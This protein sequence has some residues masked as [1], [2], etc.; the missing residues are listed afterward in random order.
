MIN[1]VADA[2]PTARARITA[3]LFLATIILGIVAQ[4]FISDRLVVL[5]DASKTAANILANES[6][7]RTGFTL[8]MVEM[9]CQIAMTLMFYDLLKPVNRSLARTAMILGLVG[10]GIK[11]V[12]RLFFY[13]PLVLLSGPPALPAFDAAELQSLSLAFLRVNDYGA[14][15]ALIFFGLETF[16]EGWLTFKSTFLPKFLGVISL[17]AGLGW[18]TFIWPPLGYQLFMVVA[19]VGLL[20][21][22]LTIGWLLI[23]GVD[24]Q[25][26][27]EQAALAATS[28]WR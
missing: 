6:L 18:A 20:G 25:R 2:S 1:T 3:V 9:V 7:F 5:S 24:D 28:I 8:Y 21:A 22:V 14:G 23:R 19:L 26:W 17:I 4:T 16:L 11:I 27:R 13:A 15:I 12:A 10:C